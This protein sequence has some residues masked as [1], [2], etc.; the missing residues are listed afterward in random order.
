MLF[1][2]LTSFWRPVPACVVVACASLVQP[3]FAVEPFEIRDIR[4]EG[5]QRG[6]PGS[7]FGALPFRIGDTY[8]DEKGTAAM[9]AL[10]ATGLFK[11]VKIEQEGRTVVIVVA[12]RTFISKLYFTGLQEF[13][14]DAILK[15]LKDNG[16]AP[17]LPFDDAL[18]DRA[19]QEIKRQYLSRSFYGVTVKTTKTPLERNQIDLTFDVSEGGIAYIEDVRVFGAQTFSEQDLLD[20]LDLTTSGWLTWY[21]RSDRYARA[22]LQGDM[23]KIRSHYLNNGFLEFDFT[24]QTP[25]GITPDKLHTEIDLQ[26]AEGTSYIVDAVRLEGDYLGQEADFRQRVSIRPGQPYRAD[27]VAATVREFMELYGTFGYAFARVE[28]RPEID[29]A[30]GLVTVVL[31]AEPRQ[32]VAVRRINIAGNTLTR[33]E[34]IRRQFR[35][36]ESAWYDG[37]KIKLSRDRVERLGFFTDVIITTEPVADAEDKV[38]LLLT[39]VEKPTGSLM[40]SAGYSNA[41]QLTL[42]ASVRKDNVFGTGNYLG[43]DFSTGKY[44]RSMA[45]SATDPYFTDDGVSRSV[46]VYYRTTRPVNS[47]GSAYQLATPGM[48]V[49]FGIP[50]TETDTIFVGVGAEQMRV[51]TASG[52]PNSYFLH[53]AE[54]GRNSSG[55]PLTLGWAREE[56]DNPMAPTKGSYKRINLETSLAGDMRYARLN[57][58]F[59]QYLPVTRK[60]TL[61]LNA[62]VGAGYGLQGRSYPV[63]KNFYGGG[64]GSVRGFEQSSLGNLDVTGAFNGGTR[65]VNLNSELY[66]PLPGSGN[67]KTL[68][69]FAFADAGNVW[70]ENQ[71]MHWGDLRASTGVGL[72]WISPVGP[73]KLSYGRP[74]RYEATDKIQRFQ[75]QIG[76]AF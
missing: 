61:G 71:S 45:V 37:R 67:D 41:E 17:G 36:F 65:R 58:Q 47:V 48:A 43:V 59:Q 28:P 51:G 31:R 52:I 1:P 63:F 39:V 55:F 18:I 73:L 24:S 34:V 3:A 75:F 72:S 44:S 10:F 23:E 54:F 40:L 38:D 8:S 76:T 68:R 20:M 64:L 11:D 66:F 7:V 9:R 62:E 22:K 57:S 56:R 30:R 69:I 42:A 74:V 35:Q 6:D 13:D 5:L 29:R 25:V 14:K 21:T 19:S 26:I 70:A 50:Y 4:I 27:D 32:R 33:D 15:A 46:E 2:S 16:I 60:L 49:R 53:V 12:E